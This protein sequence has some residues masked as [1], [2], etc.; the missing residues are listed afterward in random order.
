MG[1]KKINLPYN[2]NFLEPYIDE[3]TMK[4]HYDV[5]HRGYEEKLNNALK[6]HNQENLEKKYP[7]INDLMKNYQS[8]ENK[9]LKIAIRE[10]GGG[11]INHNFLWT[12]LT[13]NPKQLTED[14]NLK[15]AIISKWGSF[16]NF[17]SEFE[18]ESLSLFGSGW[19]WLVK[20]GGKGIKIIKTF[21]QDNPW[22]LNFTP[23]IG[24][25][26]WEHSYYLKHNA[27]R[28]EYLSDFWSV[29]DWEKAE[30]RFNS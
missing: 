28:K 19:V 27:N 9:E 7:T 22:F 25:D 16:E 26:L 21:N 14:G 15:K 4:F 18:K 13:K 12:E 17:K 8:I 2:Y 24:V 11:L 30:E 10:F 20:R 29:I 1:Y 5:H 23:I 6:T 3:Q